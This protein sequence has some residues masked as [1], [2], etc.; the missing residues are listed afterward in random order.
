MSAH[1]CRAPGTPETTIPPM[2]TV[3]LNGSA[4]TPW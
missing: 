1:P 2:N 4:Q 3:V